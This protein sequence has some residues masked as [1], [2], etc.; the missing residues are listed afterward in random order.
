MNHAFYTATVYLVI[1]ALVILSIYVGVNSRMDKENKCNT[2]N[3]HVLVIFTAIM[4]WLCVILDGNMAV[5]NFVLGLLRAIEHSMAPILFIM[6]GKCVGSNKYTKRMLY[7]VNINTLIQFL[8]IFTGWAFFYTPEH[9]YMH[10]FLYYVMYLFDA[11]AVCYLIGTF[12]H[13]SRAYKENNSMML[14]VICIFMFVTIMIHI[15]DSD[16]HLD[17]IG[18]MLAVILLY[19]YLEDFTKQKKEQEMASQLEITGALA[20]GYEC[21]YVVDTVKRTFTTVRISDVIN[22]Q[23][24]RRFI[25]DETSYSDGM[26]A[27]AKYNVYEKDLEDFLKK[28]ELQYVISELKEKA[29]YDFEYRVLRNG[30]V[31]YFSMHAVKRHIDENGN[32]TS[33]VVAFSNVDDQKNRWEKLVK[34]SNTDQMSGLLN[35]RACNDEFIRIDGLSKDEKNN[36]TAVMMDLNGLKTTN[37]TLGHE[38]GDELIVG[39]SD[40]MMKIYGKVGK[41]Y[42][43]GG[44]EFV[45]I[46]DVLLEEAVLLNDAF[47]RELASWE[48]KFSK[49]MSAAMGMARFSECSEGDTTD[50][51]IKMADERMYNDKKEY[52]KTHDRRR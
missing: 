12:V 4:E 2:L 32:I 10:G 20:A 6:V 29:S 5:P 9:V 26:N 33:L 25:D 35:R 42:R 13:F 52:Y 27:Y 44:D 15:I 36:I 21:V 37:D 18:T 19:V 1:A 23:F 14:V 30:H 47:R 34:M 11:V 40:C 8:S 49:S 24:G 22:E 50:V 48:G 38:A 43:M 45:V 17:Y 39:M 3:M 51:L 28:S 41:C 46:M 16:I 31:L 7:I